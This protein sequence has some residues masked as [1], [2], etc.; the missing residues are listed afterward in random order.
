MNMN[1]KYHQSKPGYITMILVKRDQEQLKRF[2]PA[3]ATGFRAQ[4]QCQRRAI[5]NYACSIQL[6]LLIQR[7]TV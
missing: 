3:A 6:G 5:N 4:V 1:S 7:L 2:I